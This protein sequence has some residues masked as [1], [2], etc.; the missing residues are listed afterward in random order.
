M[1]RDPLRWLGS[2]PVLSDRYALLAEES[3]LVCC[4]GMWAMKEVYGN[5]DCGNTG[6]G[7]GSASD[8]EDRSVSVN[9]WYIEQKYYYIF[10]SNL[11]D[12]QPE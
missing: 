1:P 2:L 3:W 12:E 4:T 7:A 5:G 6:S 8:A 11:A 9:G 10:D